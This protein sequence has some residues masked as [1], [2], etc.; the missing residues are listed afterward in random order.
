MDNQNEYKL[1]QDALHNILMEK[2]KVCKK[3]EQQNDEM[4]LNFLRRLLQGKVVLNEAFYSIA[5]SYR[6]SFG[7][8]YYA[9]V[10]FNIEEYEKLFRGEENGKKEDKLKLVNYILSNVVEEMVRQKH[11]GYT[12]EIDHTMACLVNVDMQEPSEIKKEILGI[13]EEAKSFIQNRLYITLT[14]SVSDIHDS[15]PGI[16]QAYQEAIEAMEYRMVVGARQ[17]IRYDA[18]KNPSINYR[19]PMDLEYKL[20]NN[21][22][23]GNLQEAENIVDCIISDNIGN[24]ILSIDMAKCLMFNLVSTMIK[25]MNE[26]SKS[27]DKDLLQNIDPVERIERM[28]KCNTIMDMRVYMKQTLKEICGY[29]E[30]KKQSHNADLKDEIIRF[31][32]DHFTDPAMSNAMIAERFCIH[33]AY[34][35]RFF[36]EQT[37]EKV[38][39]YINRIRL[40]EAKQLLQKCEINLEEV[41]RKTGFNNSIALIR[42]FKKYEGITPGKYKDTMKQ[43]HVGL[44]HWQ[45]KL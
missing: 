40:Q 2:E 18:I 33:P 20:I 42:V 26:F 23:A 34:L 4:R 22:K 16:P 45:N 3:L 29:I 7:P 8:G 44:A 5:E 21:I 43:N 13:I 17:I 28:L 24:G 11:R 38:L 12:V 35:S 27:S 10:L 25:T 14:V 31:I 36:K 32:R 1:I 6:L 41:A 37:G 15:V 30:N 19:Y 9:V 39:D